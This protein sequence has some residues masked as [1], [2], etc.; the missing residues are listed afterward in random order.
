MSLC[1]FKNRQSS[2]ETLWSG[3]DD[4]EMH[5][6]YGRKDLCD[7]ARALASLCFSWLFTGQAADA[8]PGIQPW[9]HSGIKYL[10]FVEE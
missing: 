4:L 1:V 3:G 10:N 9:P 7:G 8:S 5:S 6:F 2:N